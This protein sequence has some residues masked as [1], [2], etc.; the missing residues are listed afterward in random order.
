LRA[1]PSFRS[2]SCLYARNREE[3][4]MTIQLEAIIGAS[5]EQ[6]YGV[7]ADGA[8]FAEATGMPGYGGT[9]EGEFFSVHDGNTVGRQVEL[10]PGVRVV[11]AMR[12]TAWEAGVGSL[13]TFTLAP[14]PGGTRLTLDQIGYPPEQHDHLLAGY[15]AFYFTPLADYFAGADYAARI[16]IAVP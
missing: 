2:G 9:A 1:A 16:Q 3:T 11:R 10:V 12:L 5:P 15:P 6:V 7:L 14:A 8:A 13:L 4:V